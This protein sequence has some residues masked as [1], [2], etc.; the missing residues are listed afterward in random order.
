MGKVISEILINSHRLLS[1]TC[2]S[3]PVPIIIDNNL[4]FI[5]FPNGKCIFVI[6]LDGNEVMQTISV[7]ESYNM[8]IP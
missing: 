8:I 3:S 1:N 6:H 2:R 4:T 5:A 7:T